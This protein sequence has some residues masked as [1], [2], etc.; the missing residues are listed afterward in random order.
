MLG[1]LSCFDG[2]FDERL[3]RPRWGVGGEASNDRER[4]R[5]RIA[6]HFENARLATQLSSEGFGDLAVN[7]FSVVDQVDTRGDRYREIDRWKPISWQEERIR[8]SAHD[9]YDDERRQRP[10][11][12]ERDRLDCSGNH[13][14]VLRIGTI[15]AIETDAVQRSPKGSIA[16]RCRGVALLVRRR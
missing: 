4:T 5:A 15:A 6:L 1:Q 9:E 12:A 11:G 7:L 3:P 14:I 16:I 8:R 13:H 10:A 2:S